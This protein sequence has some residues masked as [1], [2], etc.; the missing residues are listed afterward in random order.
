VATVEAPVPGATLTVA[1]KPVAVHASSVRRGM[2]APFVL[3]VIGIVLV[4]G[5]VASV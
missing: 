1:G 3:K 5:A 4:G 2:A